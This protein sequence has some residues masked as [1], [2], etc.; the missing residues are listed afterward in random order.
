MEV[1]TVLSSW[2]A[3]QLGCPQ[4]LFGAWFL[5]PLWNRRNAALSDAALAA[6]APVPTDRVLEIGFGGGYLLGRLAPLLTAGA[7]VGVDVSATMVRRAQRRYRG[8][9]RTGRL[10]LRC[11][12][13]ESLPFDQGTFT[14]VCSVN[15]VFYWDDPAR[16]FAECGRLLVDDG[17][18]VLCL[19]CPRSLAKR[20]FAR[21][22]LKLLEPTEVEQQL[23]AAG[24]H[25]VRT[26]LAA[27]QHR[28][29][30]CCAGTKTTGRT[31]PAV[32]TTGA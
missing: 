21:H 26:S 25:D 4:G 3:R 11:A 22:G 27:D 28:D 6:L 16:A 7:L 5:A 14:K 12:P 29:F 8:L 2:F 9:V 32:A 24:F 23:A 20:G 1:A 31:S 15:S 19:T 10:D 30:F 17:R 13:A 18:L